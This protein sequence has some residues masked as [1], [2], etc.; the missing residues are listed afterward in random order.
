MCQLF[1]LFNDYMFC[2]MFADQSSY[3]AIT[4]ATNQKL[5][6]N[7]YDCIKCAISSSWQKKKIQKNKMQNYIPFKT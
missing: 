4:E 6:L 5:L 2:C 1:L 7:Q 3:L